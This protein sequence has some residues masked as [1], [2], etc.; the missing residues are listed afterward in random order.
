M[1]K[2]LISGLMGLMAS[3]SAFAQGTPSVFTPP[4]GTNIAV[5]YDNL[6][7]FLLWASLIGC[8]ILLGGMLYF[9]M[10]YRRRTDNDKTAYISHSTILEFIWSFIP[11]MIFMGVFVWG[12]IIFHQ[13]RT[14]PENG[15]EVHVFAR[16]WAWDFVY[17]SGKKVTNELVVP[18]NQDIKLI[19]TSADVLH[20]F[21]IPSMRIKQDVVPG[22]YTALWFRAEKTGNYHVFCTE[23]CGAAH[24]QM[25]ARM[26]VVSQEEY[27]AWLQESDEDLTL[28]QKGAKLANSKGCI[29]CHS[30]D[31]SVKVGPTWK[32]LWG[33]S[34]HEMVTGTKINVDENY[35]RESI[36]NPNAQVVKG[37]PAG[38]MPTYQGQ[39]SE[40]ELAALIEYIKEL[41][42]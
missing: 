31:G 21:Y 12:W 23:F 6:Y 29:A 22:M 25:L 34:N 42:K 39:V 20:S 5:Q 2:T 18:V 1:T 33:K 19:M 15:L 26:K 9:V 10:K 7:A 28:A 13:M 16:Q 17:K 24:S 8:I 32:G 30:V 4:Q 14:M 40:P 38:V 3:S 27:E 37:Y 11:L 36:L 41:A 35:L